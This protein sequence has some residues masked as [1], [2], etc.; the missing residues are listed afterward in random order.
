V[1]IG[2]EPEKL[3]MKRAAAHTVVERVILRIIVG[4]LSGL[5]RHYS[6]RFTSDGRTVAAISNECG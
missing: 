3:A 4:G 1:S 5:V 6:V 2:P